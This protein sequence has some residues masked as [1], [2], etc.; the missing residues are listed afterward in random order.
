MD[1]EN[2]KNLFDRIAREAIQQTEDIFGQ[3]IPHKYIVEL[4]GAGVSGEQMTDQKALDY[5]Y[6]DSETVYVIIDVGVKYITD[7]LTILYVRISSYPPCSFS[8]SWNTPKGN[9]PFKIITPL[10]L[11][12]KDA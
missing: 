6:I 2:F 9:G 8:E 5:L 3:I 10:E 7:N 12:K 4:H 11:I 1:K